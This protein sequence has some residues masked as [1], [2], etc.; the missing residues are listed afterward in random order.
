MSQQPNNGFV[1]EEMPLNPLMMRKMAIYG[2]PVEGSQQAPSMR[3]EFY[4][5]NFR[6]KVWTGT[7]DQDGRAESITLKFDYEQIRMFLMHLHDIARSESTQPEK[8]VEKNLRM[9]TRPN[10]E[11]GAKLPD[12]EVVYGRDE[13][14]MIYMVFGSW[15]K[16]HCVFKFGLTDWHQYYDQ[17]GKPWAEGFASRRRAINWTDMVIKQIDNIIFRDQKEEPKKQQ[18]GNRGGG[19]NR[20]GNGGGYGGGNRSSGGN[21]GGGYGGGNSGGSDLDDD[22]PY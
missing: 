15:K 12:G 11:R 20:S 8:H 1:R 2:T 6:L 16:P 4:N 9:D 5:N 18:Q 3:P 21:G 17:N 7:K 19:G 22:L 10:A 13:N 14:G